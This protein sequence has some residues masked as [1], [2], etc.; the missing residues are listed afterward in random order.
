MQQVQICFLE[1]VKSCCGYSGKW[2]TWCWESRQSK[3]WVQQEVNYNTSSQYISWN[4]LHNGDWWSATPPNLRALS[5]NPVGVLRK[6]WCPDFLRSY[7]VSVSFHPFQ[8]T[9]GP[10][11]P[12]FCLFIYLNAALNTTSDT[13]PPLPVPA[14][15][16]RTSAS[17]S[18]G[19][20][21]RYNEP[22]HFC[23]RAHYCSK[24]LHE[25]P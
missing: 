22:W 7:S 16:Y 23:T 17:L 12:S 25:K 13:V 9:C 11:S 3:K 1:V 19:I 21:T 18:P 4:T 20:F 10:A 15:S 5:W 2:R 6:F 24:Y 14:A 8:I